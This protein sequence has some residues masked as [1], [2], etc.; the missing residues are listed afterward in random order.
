M[1]KRK[2]EIAK[3]VASR[4]GLTI[5]VMRVILDEILIEIRNE[6]ADGN[7]IQFRG[8][9][10]MGS[11]VSASKLATDFQHPGKRIKVNPRVRPTIKFSKEFI[12]EVEK[13]SAILGH[14]NE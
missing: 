13:R 5:D 1:T 7:E 9:F 6:V 11:K 2:L 8:F 4:S 14:H 12:S 10:A 3:A